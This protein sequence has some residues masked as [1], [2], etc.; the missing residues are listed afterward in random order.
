VGS[1]LGASF[2]DSVLIGDNNPGK[3]YEFPLNGSRDGFDLAAPLDDLIADNNAERDLL[4]IGDG[5]G[6][7]TDLE[8][9]PDGLV[10]VVSLSNGAIYTLPEPGAGGLWVGAFVLAVLGHVRNR[11]PEFRRRLRREPTRQSARVAFSC[12]G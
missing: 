7:V 11:A 2:D 5:F 3:I 10:Y 9:G 6:A 12:R 8:V 4:A 1:A